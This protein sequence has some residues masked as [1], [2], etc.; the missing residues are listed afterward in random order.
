MI[1]GKI[2]KTTKVQYRIT[3]Q[4]EDIFEWLKDDGY[5]LPSTPGDIEA[6]VEQRSTAEDGGV[7]NLDSSLELNWTVEGM[8]EVER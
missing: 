6:Y 4:L 7:F 3:V 8:E 5:T 2:T 1:N